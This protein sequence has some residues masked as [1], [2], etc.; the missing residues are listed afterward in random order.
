M[1]YH[2]LKQPGPCVYSRSMDQ[3][4]PR[5]CINCGTPEDSKTTLLFVQDNQSFILGME[6]ALR[7]IRNRRKD[8]AALQGKEDLEDPQQQAVATCEGVVRL[9]QVEI[10]SGRMRP[11]YPSEWSPEEI[12]EVERI[13]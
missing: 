8:I 1:N 10:G 7:I 6:M 3:P 13:A 4:Y 11:P 9:V 5:H 12:D 2:C